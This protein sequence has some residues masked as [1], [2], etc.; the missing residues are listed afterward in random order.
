[1]PNEPS[2]DFRRMGW[3]D[4]IHEGLNAVGGLTV[5]VVR[6]R[7]RRI[8]LRVDANGG[9]HLTVPKWWATLHEGEDFLRSKWAW[10]LKTRE[11][12]LARPI[13]AH[14]P[15]SDAELE[16]LRVLLGELN[17]TW[18]ARLGERDVAWRIRRV[19]SLWGCCH[20]RRRYITYNA[21]L[22]HVPRELVE[23]VV[24][25]ELTHFAVHG[26]GPAFYSL[27]DKRLPGWRELRRRLNG[28]DGQGGVR[29][30]AAVS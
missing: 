26:H 3:D 6:K 25:H 18:S 9:V 30:S 11:K 23:Y 17:E 19:K 27:M 16:S 4:V 2:E 20:W 8:N 14:R 29:P 24:V 5:E 22:A 7:C 13:V 21:E 1:M 12:V 10:I 28:R 15:V